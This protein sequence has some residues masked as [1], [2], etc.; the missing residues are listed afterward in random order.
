MAQRVALTRTQNA[1]LR[2]VAR[3]P[4]AASLYWTGGTLLA[5]HYLHHRR[6]LDLGFFTEDLPDDLAVADAFQTI[7]AAVKA[8]RVTHVRHPNRWQYFFS[9]PR[10]ELKVELVYFPFPALARRTVHPSVRLRMDSLRDLAANKA[11]AAYERTEP[12]DVFDLYT[13][14]RHSGWSLPRVLR[15]VERKF[16]VAL[17]LV[18]VVAKLH[19]SAELLP[20][21]R[22][23]AV[24]PLPEPAEI[25]A[26]FQPAANQNLRRL[27]TQS[28]K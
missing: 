20:D 16:G 12:R 17:D 7:R 8:R 24:G 19:A 6:S 9:F 14:L 21:L 4:I 26:F 27:F 10:G 23:L 2:A 5:T 1:V 18:H 25:Q 15:D 3:S 22:P 11:H 13:I 28:R